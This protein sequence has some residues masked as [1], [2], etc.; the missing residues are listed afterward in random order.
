MRIGLISPP[1]VPVPPPAY[2]G[3]EAVVDRMARGFVRDGHEVLLAAPANSSCPVPLVPGT[4]AVERDAPIAGD[5]VTELDHVARA[6]AA[7]ADVDVIHDHTR[8]GPLYRH[9]P[10]GIPVVT[11]SHGPFTPDLRH[12]FSHMQCDTSIVAISHHQASTAARIEISRVIHHGLDLDRVPAGQGRGGYA[13]FLGRMNP[14]KG[15]HEAI[16]VARVAGVPLKIAAKMR[17]PEEREYFEAKVAPLLSE[18]IEYLG[19]VD[20]SGKYELLGGA[21]ALLNPIQWPEPFGLVMIEALACGTPVVTTARG[22]APEIV[23]DGR[24]GYLRADL[25]SLASLLPCA[26]A[27]DR[28]ACRREV[29][30]R[31]ST[32][33]MV[34]DHGE[35]YAELVATT[36]PGVGVRP[37]GP[38]AWAPQPVAGCAGPRQGRPTL[39][40]RSDPWEH[41]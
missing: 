2:G 26:A 31:F 10:P 11:T 39:D 33:R 41:R 27:L 5:A 16:L 22:A 7:L 17:E 20:E 25:P 40:D 38:G 36:R 14:E 8:S 18:D 9:R 37:A 30:A 32:G 13:A 4:A 12:L 1:W 34:R 15:I 35:L 29:E 23:D 28:A 24:T 19:E 3:L 6:Y 21:V